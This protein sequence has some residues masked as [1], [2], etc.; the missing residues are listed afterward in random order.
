MKFQYS[1]RNYFGD[2]CA[3][4]IIFEMSRK[5]K[6][7]EPFLDGNGRVIESVSDYARRMKNSVLPG[8]SEEVLVEWLYRHAGHVEKYAFLDFQTFTFSRQIWSLEK[9]PGREAFDDSRFCDSFSNV[10]ERAAR[11]RDWLA[12][13]MLERGTWNTPIVLLGNKEGRH[14]F[15]NGRKLKQ[16]FHL[17]EGHRRLSFLIGLRSKGKALPNHVVWLV[18]TP[19]NDN[20]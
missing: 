9:M 5:T 8:W 20:L 7:Y 12:N 14:Q 18:E 2:R 10:A 16:P 3:G 1:R 4:F 13:Y 15:K 17:L 6:I 19:P 11:G